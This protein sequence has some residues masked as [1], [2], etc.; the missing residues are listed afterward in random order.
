[1]LFD[2]L[3]NLWPS[4]AAGDLFPSALSGEFRSPVSMDSGVNV[5]S[6]RVTHGR[7][8]DSEAGEAMVVGVASDVSEKGEKG[9]KGDVESGGKE[10][11]GDSASSAL[12]TASYLIAMVMGAAC[13]RGPALGGFSASWTG[14]APF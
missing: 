4:S 5:C 12:S 2:V 13:D 7:A 8:D 3:N 9:E 6:A 10:E 1:M 11:P 14:A